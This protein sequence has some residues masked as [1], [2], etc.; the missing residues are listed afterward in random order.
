VHSADWINWWEHAV[1]WMLQG[2]TPSG[3]NPHLSINTALVLIK[4]HLDASRTCLVLSWLCSFNWTSQNVRSICSTSC[5]CS[6]AEAFNVLIHAISWCWRWS[7]DAQNLNTFT[8]LYK[9]FC[10]THQAKNYPRSWLASSLQYC[11]IVVL[12]VG[13]KLQ[14]CD[15]FS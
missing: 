15:L 5:H 11:W 4:M 1:S 8:Q 9:W 6:R 3:I 7:R 14:T 12:C 2:S 10:T 13:C